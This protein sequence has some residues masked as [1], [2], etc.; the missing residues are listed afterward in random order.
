MSFLEN[1]R[2]RNKLMLLLIFPV[3]GLLYFSVNGVLEKYRLTGE[4]SSL[5][6]LSAL[7]VKI[8]ALVHETQKERGMTAGFL[9]SKGAAFGS[10][11]KSQR[12][13]TDKKII[14]LRELL[15]DFDRNRFGN[16]FTKNLNGGLNLLDLIESKRDAISGLNIS[17][18]EAIG[19]YTNMNAQFLDVIAYVARLS[20]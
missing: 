16:E 17:A 7:A 12:V 11:L 10:E 15:R 3:L 13:E 2:L 8:S 6:N 19:Y 9:G 1:V 20:S 5:Q 18:N 4:M 14:E